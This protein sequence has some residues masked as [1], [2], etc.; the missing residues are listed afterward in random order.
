MVV[1]AGK[2]KTN[3]EVGWI[4][5]ILTQFLD[6]VVYSFKKYQ[7]SIYFSVNMPVKVTGSCCAMAALKTI[8][9][10]S[11]GKNIFILIF[12]FRYWILVFVQSMI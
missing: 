4:D 12:I 3:S 1:S 9:L 2:T 6:L 10:T 8:K 7:F 5:R 11:K